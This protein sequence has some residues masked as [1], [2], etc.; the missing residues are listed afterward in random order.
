V[1]RLVTNKEMGSNPIR[2]VSYAHSN[3]SKGI[4]YHINRYGGDANVVN[5]NYQFY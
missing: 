3:T 5:I 1:L 2:R 4:K